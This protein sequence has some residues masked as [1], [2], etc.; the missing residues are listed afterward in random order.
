[1]NAGLPLL[2]DDPGDVFA[3]VAAPGDSMYIVTPGV[4]KAVRREPGPAPPRL[5]RLLGEG[6]FFGE[7]SILSGRPRT[8]TVTA[9]TACEL[10]ELDRK[11][12][13]E[14]T[15]R[16]PNVRAVLEEFYVQRAGG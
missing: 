1:V 9:A 4:V 16:H 14:I 13:D 2:R 15:A 8:A 6:E 11:T 5:A 7:V 12:L 3:L 10:L